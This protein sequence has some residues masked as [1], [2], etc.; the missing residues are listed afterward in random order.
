M[1]VSDRHADPKELRGTSERSAVLRRGVCDGAEVRGRRRRCGALS[2]PR[3]PRTG[4][5]I[6][7]VDLDVARLRWAA[8]TVLP[9]G[10]NPTCWAPCFH[11]SGGVI[12]RSLE[13]LKYER[14]CHLVLSYLSSGGLKA[15]ALPLFIKKMLGNNPSIILLLDR[16]NCVVECVLLG[17]VV[18]SS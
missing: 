18:A 2:W 15:K 16:V 7:L 17:V 8:V 6:S 4:G 13:I 11:W 10:S 3:N 1:R 5:D 9:L 14:S 12:A